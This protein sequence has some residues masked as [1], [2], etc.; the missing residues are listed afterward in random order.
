MGPL[1][2]FCDVWG[3]EF[4]K[5][6]Y[7]LSH[8][9]AS[10]LPSTVFIGMC[11]G[12]PLLSFIAE[13]TKHYLGTIVGAGITMCVVFTLLVSGVLT[14]SSISFGFIITGICCAYQIIAIYKAST[15]V[16]EHAAGL[17]TAIANMI[18][19]I[20]GYAFHS[21][22]GAIIKYFGTSPEAFA[23]GISIIPIALAIGVGGVGYL[24]VM[25]KK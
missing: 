7:G 14:V 5:Q 4:L 17:T 16:P 20:F 19:M 18:I 1:E 2:G 9:T 21:S 11:C 12:A 24:I 25:D 6:F 23:Y 3:T 8:L 22:I 10:S 15:Y 13:K